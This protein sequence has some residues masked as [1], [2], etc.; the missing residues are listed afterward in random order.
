MGDIEVEEGLIGDD[1][2]SDIHLAILIDIVGLNVLEQGLMD[3]TVRCHC[4]CAHVREVYLAGELGA[5]DSVDESSEDGGACVF[6]PQVH[7]DCDGCADGNL[8][9]KRNLNAPITV[10]TI[11][12]SE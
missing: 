7:S 9:V 10:N 3:K 6:A 11:V 4:R 8:I 12:L 5:W 1:G 2:A